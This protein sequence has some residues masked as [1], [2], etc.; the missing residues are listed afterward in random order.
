MGMERLGEPFAFTGD[1][2]GGRRARRAVRERAA[3]VIADETLLDDVE[4]MA[5]EG[6][7]N[8][9]LH[10]TGIVTVTVAT[11]GRRIRVDITDDGPA[12]AD[13]DGADPRLDHGRGLTV[14]DALADEWSFEQSPHRT[15]LRF[16]VDAVLTA[17]QAHSAR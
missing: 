5:A 15:R 2:D 4:L 16:L 11:D 6:V 10:G 8:A 13:A 1:G 3:K 14:I 12:Q 17:D 9:I 7:A